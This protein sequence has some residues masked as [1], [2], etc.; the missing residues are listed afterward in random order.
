[1]I[2]EAEEQRVKKGPKKNK[3][4]KEDEDYEE[5]LDDV[6]ADPALRKEMNLYKNSKVL[7]KD[8]TKEQ[9]D[10]IL[11]E[12]DLCELFDDMNIQEAQ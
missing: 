12:M 11:G 9:L 10:E 5:F 2:E 4:N 6:E 8:M 7:K 3:K 1:M